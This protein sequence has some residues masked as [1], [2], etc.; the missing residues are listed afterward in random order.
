MKYATTIKIRYI[1]GALCVITLICAKANAQVMQE[2]SRP[3]VEVRLNNGSKLIGKYVALIPEQSLTITLYDKDTITFPWQGMKS[4]KIKDN[5]SNRPKAHLA[6]KGAIHDKLK[7]TGRI[8]MFSN[9]QINGVGA[10]VGGLYILNSRFM[11][12]V[13]LGISNYSENDGENI[14]K[15]G[16]ETRFYILPSAIS[17][18]IYMKTGYGFATTSERFDISEAKG[19][20]YYNPGIGFSFGHDLAFE[21]LLGLNFQSTRFVYGSGENNSTTERKTRRVEIGLGFS[22]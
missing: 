16:N 9:N 8:S 18:F 3:T 17:P 5:V 2:N 20:L 12:G 21:L 13:S 7:I 15:I 11:S 4:F 14:L 1:L 19:A 22:F 6:R 10:S